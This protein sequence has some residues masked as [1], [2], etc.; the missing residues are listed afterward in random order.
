MASRHE[1]KANCLR[2]L[3]DSII[4]TLR[5][6]ALFKQH[7]DYQKRLNEISQELEQELDVRILFIGKTGEGK[8]QILNILLWGPDYVLRH[9]QLSIDFFSRSPAISEVSAN[10]QTK[11][12]SCYS[13]RV[14]SFMIE[15]RFSEESQLAPQILFEG[16]PLLPEKFPH[17]LCEEVQFLRNFQLDPLSFVDPSNWP[18]LREFHFRGPWDGLKDHPNVILVDT[19]GLNEKLETPHLNLQQLLRQQVAKSQAVIVFGS[20]RPTDDV[21]ENL[22]TFDLFSIDHPK[23]LVGC[24]LDESKPLPPLNLAVLQ[25]CTSPTK[26]I[27]KW[28]VLEKKEVDLKSHLETFQQT[29]V[30]LTRNPKIL[31]HIDL[32]QKRNFFFNLAAQAGIV[33]LDLVT[34]Q[35]EKFWDNLFASLYAEPITH[36]LNSLSMLISEML[37][38][39]GQDSKLLRDHFVS[40]MMTTITTLSSKTT[41]LPSLLS[42]EIDKLFAPM[43]GPQEAPFN[44]PFWDFCRSLEQIR[45]MDTFDPNHPAFQCLN[46]FLTHVLGYT[47]DTPFMRLVF[48]LIE[49]E[50]ATSLQQGDT[51]NKKQASSV[52]SKT[53]KKKKAKAS[54]PPAPSSSSKHSRKKNEAASDPAALE[55]ACEKMKNT[56]LDLLR[57]SLDEINLHDRRHILLRER[58]RQHLRGPDFSSSLVD[59][60]VEE[61]HLLIHQL[62]LFLWRQD[63]QVVALTLQSHLDRITGL[64]K[65]HTSEVPYSH[66]T[67]TC[68][69][70][71]RL[72]A[73]DT[74][75]NIKTYRC[76]F[77]STLQKLS[78]LLILDHNAA[79][80]ESRAKNANLSVLRSFVLPPL[81]RHEIDQMCEALTVDPPLV[82]SS[83]PMTK[84]SNKKRKRRSPKITP[85]AS[86]IPLFDRPLGVISSSPEEHE[87]QGPQNLSPLPPPW[88]VIE[89]TELI[90]PP[91]QNG[92][93]YL[94]RFPTLDQS[95][96]D[97]L[98]RFRVKSHLERC[99]RERS[100]PVLVFSRHFAQHKK[101]DDPL[102][103]SS[104]L[105]E[106]ASKAC[107]Q[108]AVVVVPSLQLPHYRQLDLSG[109]P[110]LLGPLLVVL[111]GVRENGHHLSVRRQVNVGLEFIRQWLPHHPWVALLDHSL[112]KLSQWNPSLVNPEPCDL[113]TCLLGVLSTLEHVESC[114]FHQ[115]KSLLG[116]DKKPWHFGFCDLDLVTLV[117]E[118]F[119]Q[120]VPDPELFTRER[121]YQFLRDYV[122]LLG[123]L[124]PASRA[125]AVAK[126]AQV[127]SVADR[128]RVLQRLQFL[129]RPWDRVSRLMLETIPHQ[130]QSHALY[131]H[132][133]FQPV[134]GF[135]LRNPNGL[136]FLHVDLL[137]RLVSDDFH[138]EPD[139]SD[140]SKFQAFMSLPK[141]LELLARPV[142]RREF[143]SALNLMCAELHYRVHHL[144][145]Q[146]DRCV[147]LN[148]QNWGFFT[149]NTPKK[150]VPLE[151]SSSLPATSTRPTRQKRKVIPVSL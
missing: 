138:Q 100:L 137:F 149:G 41:S 40:A 101:C 134:E 46:D 34:H 7:H 106:L 76:E 78:Q 50:M 70:T 139:L 61:C 43:S 17:D 151:E 42:E 136:C 21:M 103:L 123:D 143:A 15:A 60:S 37:L 133:A 57:V 33:S 36:C 107:P 80:V 39:H 4:S 79:W 6:H 9:L 30:S 112:K 105:Q 125:R 119:D 132:R 84:S 148:L 130:R 89:M 77:P 69:K 141:H 35:P 51:Q 56:T 62:I 127:G 49:Q 90:L 10:S 63:L 32:L 88:Q 81:Q 24:T 64:M 82:I 131:K 67:T 142:H 65:K 58:V 122:K 114:T 48:P 3:E 68:K 44:C 31:S 140:N 47:P 97:P 14:D 53:P 104:S 87:N 52:S 85:P 27:P 96:N 23:V 2:K 11:F 66:A 8:T 71:I 128:T 108:V 121:L 25:P 20:R 94:P 145:S 126:E 22:D 28:P 115:A 29:L 99:A 19:P 109:G 92:Q 116:R 146:T 74:N 110:I 12:V 95:I 72:M 113:P 86:S 147:S 111:L 59:L 38:A 16:A 144:L 5:K 75:T 1:F 45:L 26:I 55:L 118:F 54:S 13:Y 117:D 83:P 91:L 129:L 73:E 102:T 93:I 135:Y 120:V 124:S 150:I 18:H 98:Q